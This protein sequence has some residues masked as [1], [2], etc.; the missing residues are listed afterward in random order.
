MLQEAGRTDVSEE[1]CSQFLKENDNDV[2]RAFQYI[3]HFGGA[4][5]ARRTT[6]VSPNFYLPAKVNRIYA[7]KI[8]RINGKEKNSMSQQFVPIAMN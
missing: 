8:S 2:Q 1:V 7:N 6:I 3:S 4:T 5:R